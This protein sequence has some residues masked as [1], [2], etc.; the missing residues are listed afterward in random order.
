MIFYFVFLN[1]A[2]NLKLHSLALGGI[3]D[4]QNKH[5]TGDYSPYVCTISIIVV[6]H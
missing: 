6:G 3:C 5:I 2:I 1:G 4:R